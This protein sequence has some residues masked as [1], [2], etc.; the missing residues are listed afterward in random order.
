MPRKTRILHEND[1]YLFVEAPG[2]P[3][4]PSLQI[5]ARTENLRAVAPGRAPTHQT[6]HGLWIQIARFDG[7]ELGIAPE[8]PD[9][10]GERVKSILPRYVEART[11]RIGEAKHPCWWI[12]ADGRALHG[13]HPAQPAGALFKLWSSEERAREVARE[14]GIEAIVQSTGDLR[15]FLELRAEEGYAGALLDDR[16]LV[17]FCLDDQSRLQF[18]RLAPRASDEEESGL[19]TQLLASDGRFVLYEGDEKLEPLADPDGWDR[20][21]VRLY[22]TQPFLGYVPGWRCLVLRKEGAP[23]ERPDSE[24]EGNQPMIALFHDPAAADDY[25]SRHGLGRAKIERVTDLVALVRAAQLQGRIVRLQPEDH[26]LRGGPLWLDK[27][28]ALLLLGYCGIWSSRDGI[29]FERVADEETGPDIGHVHGP[30]CAHGVGGVGDLGDD[31]E[32]DER[33]GGNGGGDPAA[34]GGAPRDQS[35]GST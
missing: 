2:D 35:S 22:G 25:R 11:A 27:H 21:L 30:G 18:L 33:S 26:R 23:V 32:A 29:A 9:G 5:F 17:F 13:L 24:S 34:P 20:L 6:E 15:E 12:V 7:V 4:G 3:L 31:D 8:S 19:E 16:D 1:E 10:L 28:G 14:L